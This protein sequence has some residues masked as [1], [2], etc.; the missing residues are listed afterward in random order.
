MY[1]LH[2]LF[3]GLLRT[4]P[5][6]SNRGFA[7]GNNEAPQDMSGIRYVKRL[8]LNKANKIKV[9]FVRTLMVNSRFLSVS[10]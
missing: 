4:L 10:G 6:R 2:S 9:T 1:V 8:Y 5:R 3:D 7:S